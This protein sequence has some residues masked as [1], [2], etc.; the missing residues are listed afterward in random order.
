LYFVDASRPRRALILD[1]VLAREVAGLTG[2]PH[3]A[4]S[5]GRAR[6]WTAYRYGVYL[7]W[8]AQTAADFQVPPDFLEFALFRSWE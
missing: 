2:M 1:Q 8:M 4:D 5:H 3:L 6:R 7:A